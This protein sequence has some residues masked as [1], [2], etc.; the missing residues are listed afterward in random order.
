MSL[1]AGIPV[2]FLGHVTKSGDVG[3]P[4]MLEHMV[5]VVLSLESMDEEVKVI[6]PMKNRYEQQ[7]IDDD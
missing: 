1:L 5:D 6:R 4:K 3:G 7:L 2:I